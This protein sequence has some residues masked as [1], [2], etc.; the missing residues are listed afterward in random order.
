MIAD[1][2]EW[3]TQI[4][5]Q[6]AAAAVPNCVILSGGSPGPTVPNCIGREG[7]GCDVRWRLD[8]VV[9]RPGER[10][11]SWAAEIYAHNLTHL[12]AAERFLLADAEAKR[13]VLTQYDDAR[14]STDSIQKTFADDVSTYAKVERA[15]YLQAANA[16][17]TVVRIVGTAY[18]DRDG[19]QEG[20]RP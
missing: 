18:A 11:E 4:L 7:H 16:L 5:D 12:T 6:Q 2:V 20:W 13:S 3:L 1:L 9:V 14:E 10:P 15:A 17:G 8:G 19:Y